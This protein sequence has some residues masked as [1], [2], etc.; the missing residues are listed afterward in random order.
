MK[1]LNPEYV[2]KV[3]LL[4]NRSGYFDLLSMKIVSL[5]LGEA[6]LEI[7][8]QPK[9]LQP[10]GMVHGGVY[11][12]IVDGAT[13]WAVYPLIEEGLGLTTVELKVNF[14]APSTEGRLI[15]RG[16]SIRVGRTLCLA[17][18]FVENRK[19]L[20]LAHGTTTMMVMKEVLLTEEA[21]LP[22]RMKDRG[23][24]SEKKKLRS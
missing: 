16:K 14:L 13:F 17:E 18:C 6:V 23:Q 24:R 1:Q 10:F 21:S 7:A 9:H 11:S 5:S 4:A 2:R 8:L 22:P 19:G 20:L 15:A 3:K 12:S